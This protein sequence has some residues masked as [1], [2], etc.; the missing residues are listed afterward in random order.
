[1]SIRG[2]IGGIRKSES[3]PITHF[4]MTYIESDNYPTF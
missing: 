2:A 4:Q 3:I 1:M